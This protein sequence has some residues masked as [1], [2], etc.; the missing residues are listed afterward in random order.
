M[1]EALMGILSIG[2]GV[3]ALQVEMD[4]ADS[5]QSLYRDHHDA[6]KSGDPARRSE[7]SAAVL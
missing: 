1:D 5:R 6:S 7:S 2:L 4:A 3:S